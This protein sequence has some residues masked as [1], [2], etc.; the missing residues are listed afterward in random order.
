MDRKQLQKIKKTFI[1]KCTLFINQKYSNIL[2]DRNFSNEKLTE[3][4][5][6]IINKRD[7]KKFANFDF[8]TEIR[9]IERSILKKISSSYNTVKQ[10]TVNMEKIN[11][12]IGNNINTSSNNNKK[13]CKSSRPGVRAKV[14][15]DEISENHTKIPLTQEVKNEGNTSGVVAEKAVI[16]RGLSQRPSKTEIPYSTEKMRMLN[17]KKNDKYAIEINKD[18]DK[19]IEEEREKRENFIRQ[20]RLQREIL[21]KQIKEKKE[22]RMKDREEEKKLEM[23]EIN[24]NKAFNYWFGEDGKKNN[25]RFNT[26]YTNVSKENKLL[27]INNKEQ[28][29]ILTSNNYIRPLTSDSKSNVNKNKSELKNPLQLTDIEYNNKIKEDLKKFKEEELQRRLERLNKNKQIQQENF[30]ASERKKEERRTLKEKEKREEVSKENFYLFDESA[31]STLNKLKAIK[32]SQNEEKNAA[33]FEQRQKV[34]E[35]YEQNKLKAEQALQNQKFLLQEK[36]VKQQKLKKIEEYKKGLEQQIRE[37]AKVKNELNL[38][39]IKDREDFDM[40]N[41]EFLLEQKSNNLMK[42][43]KINFYKNLLENQ[44]RENKQKIE[45]ELFEDYSG[46]NRKNIKKN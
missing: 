11:N 5:A 19:F 26:N 27:K 28:P 45:R 9:Q 2:K 42:K 33:K 20:Q 35:S 21:E 31:N 3:E 8:K 14:K 22:R 37:K 44:I 39:K 10:A 24:D 7:I 15:N 29:T 4:I 12:L 41:K 30:L 16:K 17:L 46:G 34:I 25:V 40:K 6:K 32:L 18:H 36:E 23:E 1:N 38:N 43:E 13:Q